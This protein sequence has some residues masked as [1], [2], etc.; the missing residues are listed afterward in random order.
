[1]GVIVVGLAAVILG[2]AVMST[3]TILLA[4]VACI[5]GSVL[6][7]LVVA[8]A[9]NAEFLGLQAQ[10]LKLITAILVVAAMTLPGVRRR[11]VIARR[12]KS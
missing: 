4:T 8:F 6:Y 3:R 10:D 2:E 5:V 12:R 7:R 11:W 1:V 9:L